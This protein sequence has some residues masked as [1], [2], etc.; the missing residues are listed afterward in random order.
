MP[1]TGNRR[2]GKGIT[3][4]SENADEE[5]GRLGM[6]H[7]SGGK[8]QREAYLCHLKVLRLYPTNK[9]RFQGA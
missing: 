5:D 8:G 7:Q 6:T 2:A 3:G 9:W 4:W 1:H